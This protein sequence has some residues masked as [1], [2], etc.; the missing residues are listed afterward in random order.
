MNPSCF[1]AIG[2]SFNEKILYELP[3]EK[4]LKNIWISE[5]KFKL[6]GYCGSLGLANAMNAAINLFQ[7]QEMIK[8]I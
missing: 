7:E 6:I 2:N 3:L 8:S 1:L 4:K 5:K